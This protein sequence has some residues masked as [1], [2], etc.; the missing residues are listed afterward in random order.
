MNTLNLLLIEDNPADA[1]LI[2]EILKDIIHFKSILTSVITLKAGCEQIKKNSF[3]IILLDLNL[4]DGTGEQALEKVLS[5]CKEVPV[6][7]ITGNEDEELALKMI[8]EGAQDYNT[9]QSLNPAILGKSILYSIERKQNENKLRKSQ[10]L[11]K[12]A[13]K[14]AHLGVWNWDTILDR[15]TWSEELYQIAGLD[16]K[17]PA[18]A[19]AEHSTIFTARSWHL[20]NETIKSVMNTGEHYQLELELIR[21]DGT[22]RNVI[23]NGS[24]N[25][26]AKGQITGLL[27]TV[28]DITERKQAQSELIEANKEL[29]FQNEEKEKRA[30]ELVVTNKELSILHKQKEKQAEELYETN[31]YLE[32]LLN[33]GNTPI[34]VWNAEYKI[35]RFN[36]AFE[37]LT[38]RPETDVLGKSLDILFPPALI[39]SSMELIRE[40]FEG[41]RMDASEISILHS[42][43]SVRLLLWN[44]ANIM[45]KDGKMY[46]ATIGQGYDITER[47]KAQASLHRTADRL[48]NLHALDTAILESVDSTD[49]IAG[50][51]LQH[52]WKLLQ[53]KSTSISI[54][55]LVKKQVQL[56]ES[57]ANGKQI[58]REAKYITDETIADLKIMLQGKIEIIDDI[59]KVNSTPATASILNKKGIQSFINIPLLSVKDFYGILNIGWENPRTITP[60]ETDI[61]SEVASQITIALEKAS[62]L[63]KIRLHAA[64]LEERVTERTAQYEAANK[65]LETFSYSVSHDLRA[66]LR[67]ISGFIGLFLEHNSTHLTEEELGY[68][69]VVTKSAEDMGALIDALL[70]FSRLNRSDLKKTTINTIEIIDQGLQLFTEDIRTR[71]IEMKIGPLPQ[72]YADVQLI[73][74]VWINLISNAIKYTGKKDKAVIEIGSFV[75]KDKTNF[76]IK[77]NGAGFDMKYSDKLFGLFQRLHIQKDFDGIGIGLANINRIIKRHGGQCWAE[78]EMDKGATF[79]FSLPMEK[80]A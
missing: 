52:L 59:S 42:D 55:D 64:D 2:S 30:A 63:K 20:L 49:E 33:Y 68:L 19:F 39:N 31:E 76:F 23:V 26:N 70:A 24:P 25:F 32:K 8:S 41:E 35:I 48:K 40:T 67:H 15:V 80:S 46:L 54:I 36:R 34:I 78:G 17:F 57:D 79:Y 72:T 56:F 74:Q 60:E 11:L 71:G 7:L 66:P 75:E 14:L 37:T 47:Q 13:Q 5:C 51:S 58:V 44:S 28:Q 50:K 18:P 22:I 61:A 3:D 12:E 16:P 53:S 62:L 10:L 38:G 73:R 65:E 29:S 1:R 6:V 77:D 9:K 69:A 21:S 4:P 43:G 27:G 45:S